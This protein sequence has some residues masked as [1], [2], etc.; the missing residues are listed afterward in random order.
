MPF[1]Q[2]P[3]RTSRLDIRSELARR[4]VTGAVTR[5]VESVRKRCKPLYGYLKEAWALLE[6]DT[7]FADN[8]HLEFLCRHLE[9]ITRGEFL[10]KGLMNRLLANVPPGTMKSLLITV[11][12]PSWEWGPCD[13][14]WMQITAT[15][16]KEQ[17]CV[18]DQNR[19]R[20]LI[21][22]EWYQRHWPIRITKDSE[23]WFENDKKGWRK[24]SAYGSLTGGRSHRLI[25]DDP[26]SVDT[27]ESDLDRARA[28][29]T[30][31]ESATTR[32][33]DPA[34]S[35]IIVV[36]QRLHESDISGIILGTGGKI[37][38]APMP[39]V[40]IMLPMRFEVAR[41][42]VTPF[43][44]DPRT[45]EGELLMPNRFPKAVVDR[46][47]AAM[48]VHATAGQMQQ[49]PGP[50]GGLL[51]KRHWFQIVDA[52]PAG[53]RR[54]RGWDFAAST[55]RTSAQTA[56]VLMSHLAG[57]FYIENVIADRVE[58]PEDMV[59]ATAMQDGYGVEV[60]IP[61]DPGQ[62]GK[63]QARAMIGKLPGFTAMASPE[64]GDKISRAD[65][66]ASQAKA[67]NVY[68]VRG[69]WNAAFLDQIESFPAGALKDMIDAA[70]RAFSSFVLMPN[71]AVVVP[72]LVPGMGAGF[73]DHPGT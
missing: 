35:A 69:E 42:C 19:F 39:Y 34:T 25:I 64:S 5:D 11:V 20:N 1:T 58:N 40:H 36:M 33:N 55:E 43:G 26:H 46:D 7:P 49:R 41:R 63:V 59:V 6:P 4:S 32:L 45:R 18:R 71:A 30:F 70:S 17:N 14:P 2:K 52:V 56:G 22:S 50:R 10:A 66:L 13:M 51:F 29:T 61:Q 72:I 54:V 57:R 47:E 8:W 12:W 48:G 60:S 9:A 31:R 23:E 21:K 53:A 68:L 65:P 24:T 67:G 16:F 73:G 15:S 28:E 38:T 62:A 27:A 3:H 37:R 44:A